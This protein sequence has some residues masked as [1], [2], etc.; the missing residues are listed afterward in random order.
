MGNA[1]VDLLVFLLIARIADDTR[2]TRANGHAKA[3]R[4]PIPTGAAR[5]AHYVDYKR[6]NPTCG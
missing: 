6:S 1:S 3:Q 4:S 5:R 2:Q